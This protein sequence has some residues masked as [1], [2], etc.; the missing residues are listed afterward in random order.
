[1]TSRPKSASSDSPLALAT[2]M[3]TPPTGNLEARIHL[4]IGASTMLLTLPPKRRLTPPAPATTTCGDMSVAKRLSTLELSPPSTSKSLV[5][6]LVACHRA[7]SKAASVTSATSPVFVPFALHQTL[8]SDARMRRR[9]RRARQTPGAARAVGQPSTLLHV[10]GTEAP[11][12]CCA[13]SWN[14]CSRT[15]GASPVAGHGPM[16]A[17]CRGGFYLGRSCSSACPSD[18]VDSYSANISDTCLPCELVNINSPQHP[19][20]EQRQSESCVAD[21]AYG[22]G[23]SVLKPDFVAAAQRRGQ[24]I[25]KDLAPSHAADRLPTQAAADAKCAVQRIHNVRGRVTN[26]ELDPTMADSAPNDDI[27]VRW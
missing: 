9:D 8:L 18:D 16:L 20:K 11:A 27:F 10:H 24:C 13:P 22:Y 25:A 5:F 1:M 19:A 17:F 12:R 26:A 21:A 7:I 14:D 2:W 4:L 23:Q 6:L 3:R 15:P